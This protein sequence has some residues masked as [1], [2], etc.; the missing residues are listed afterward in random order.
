MNI[1]SFQ[2]SIS[3]FKHLTK[4]EDDFEHG[5]KKLSHNLSSLH[6]YFQVSMA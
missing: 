3:W 6:E 2:Q 1:L 4:Q 5:F